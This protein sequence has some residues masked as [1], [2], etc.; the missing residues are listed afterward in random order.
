MICRELAAALLVARHQASFMPLACT[1]TTA[2]TGHCASVASRKLARP[3]ALADPLAGWTG[4]P[5][6]R[7]D[8]G[9]AFQP[10]DVVEAQL[11]QEAE[12][13]GV[14]EAGQEGDLDV[15]LPPLWRTPQQ[16]RYD[17]SGGD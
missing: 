3:T 15:D 4:R 6:G 14:G 8:L 11:V 2:P 7:A 12:Q 10:D 16:A 9:V 1:H 13:L 17:P 5:V